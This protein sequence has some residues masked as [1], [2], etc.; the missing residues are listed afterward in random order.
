MTSTAVLTLIPRDLP[1]QVPHLRG[2]S[3]GLTLDALAGLASILASGTVLI[4]VYVSLRF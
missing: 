4:L 2:H 3:I 1:T